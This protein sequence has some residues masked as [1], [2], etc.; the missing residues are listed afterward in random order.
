MPC[1]S[2]LR[3]HMIPRTHQKK[4]VLP[5]TLWLCQNSELENGHRTSW[6]T[7]EKSMVKKTIVFWDCLP[8]G[9]RK[10]SWDGGVVLVRIRDPEIQKTHESSR[11]PLWGTLCGWCWTQIHQIRPNNNG[12]VR[13]AS[14]FIHWQWMTMTYA[15]IKNGWTEE[16]DGSKPIWLPYDWEE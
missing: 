16:N 11:L 1:K 15:D 5:P 6:F 4:M 7:H 10:V 9:I 8:E 12:L 3:S 14:I 2:F 13:F